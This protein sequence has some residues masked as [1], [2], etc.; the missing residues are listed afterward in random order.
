LKVYKCIRIQFHNKKQDSFLE[1]RQLLAMPP[2]APDVTETNTQRLPTN[3]AHQQSLSYAIVYQVFSKQSGLSTEET[4]R[5]A[6]NSQADEIARVLLRLVEDIQRKH[7][8]CFEGMCRRLEETSTLSDEAE[9]EKVFRGVSESMMRGECVTWGRILSLTSIWSMLAARRVRDE[10]S[11][12]AIPQMTRIISAYFDT[13][14]ASGIRC[15]GGWEA[16]EHA[17]PKQPEVESLI[18]NGLFSTFVG[19]GVCSLAMIAAR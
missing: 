4:P 13:E 10:L 17:F 11:G 15:L 19:L 2:N 6:W 5:N 3:S 16:L 9:L 18:W 12:E 1:D 14:L 8:A 7:E